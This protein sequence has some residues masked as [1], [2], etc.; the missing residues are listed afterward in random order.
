VRTV[1]ALRAWSVDCSDTRDAVALEL[2]DRQARNL[3]EMASVDCEHNKAQGK[4][5]RSDQQIR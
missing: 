4:R 5:G 2:R 3:F 1:P